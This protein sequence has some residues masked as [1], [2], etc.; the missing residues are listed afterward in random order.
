MRP[1][2]GKR[3]GYFDHF[4]IPMHPN[5]RVAAIA[6][7][8]GF[9]LVDV[10]HCEELA[11]VPLRGESPVAF[12]R[13]AEALLT[14]GNR[15]LYRW[16]LRFSQAEPARLD[17]GPAQLLR[18]YTP[19]TFAQ[20]ADG[21]VA[22]FATGAGAQ[23]WR[24]LENRSLDIARDQSEVGRCDVSPDGRWVATGSNELRHGV[25]AKVWD[26]ATGKLEA[27]L[28]VGRICRVWFS[29]DGKWLVTGGGGFRV[30]EVGTW[31][32][33][34]RIPDAGLGGSCAFS[35]DGRWLAI[36]D[37]P[38][39][40]RIIDPGTGLDVVRLTAPVQTR[41]Y[42][43]CFTPD[44]GKLIAVGVD[45]G[46]L[47]IFDLHLIRAQLEGLN[48]GWDDT[49]LNRSRTPSRPGRPFDVHIEVDKF[50][51]DQL[52]ADARARVQEKD[53]AQAVSLLGQA[54]QTNPGHAEAHNNLAWLLLTAPVGFR[55]SNQA[56]VHAQKANELSANTPLFGNT[57]GV[58]LYRTGRFREAVSVLE[59]DL[60]AG[61]GSQDA[62]DL[63][64]LAMA[65]HQLGDAAKAKECE[66]R[67]GRWFQERRGKLPSE[68]VKELTA[69]QA[70]T[71]AV[72]AKPAVPPKAKSP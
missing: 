39:V 25:G 16:P 47:H 66:D 1:G 51:T 54:V 65:H 35:R 29:P 26:A 69:F 55:D 42:P 18:T 53:Y 5:G 48:L 9:A 6:V 8:E 21:Q 70:E 7:D 61:T 52:L 27:D 56:L 41:L 31:R 34:P 43:K 46:T 17:V 60:E 63:F 44:G 67:G 33:G 12:E 24:P 64:F 11:V 72:L 71:R 30:W 37:K 15:G 22:A 13:S 40:V 57:L 49:G 59:K 10:E 36:C 14:M 3:S 62:F 19:G 58:A 68:W 23:I 45:T 2:S 20:S 4:A 28:P 32:E 50:I 38:G